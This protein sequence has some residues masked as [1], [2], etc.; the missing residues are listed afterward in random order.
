MEKLLNNNLSDKAKY[1]Y[2]LVCRALDNNDEKAYAEIMARYREPIYYMLLKM[3]RSE[4]DVEDLTIEAFGKAFKKLEQYEP[5]YAFSTWLYKIATN[6]CIDFIRKKKMKTLSLDANQEG[7]ENSKNYEPI[8]YTLTPEEEIIQNQKIILM[9][10][11]VDQ[12]KPR[13]K[14]L[15]ELR[16]FKEYSYQEIATEMKLPLGTVKAQLF[17]AKELLHEILKDRRNSI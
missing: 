4:V 6:N 14:A 8:A 17:R 2:T 1:D 16:Y 11:V 12:L 3:I 9:H 13:Y 5:T 15:I 10:K 7:E